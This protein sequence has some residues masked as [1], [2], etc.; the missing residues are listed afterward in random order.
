[1][2]IQTIKQ[3]QETVGELTAKVEELSTKPKTV[4]TSEPVKS[5]DKVV[6]TR[7]ASYYLAKQVSGKEDIKGFDDVKGIIATRAINPADLPNWL[8][9]QFTND[10]VERMT[11][12]ANVEK[13][14][15]HYTIP[16]NAESLSV[17]QKK[18]KIRAYLIAPSTDAINSAI[19][20]AKVTFQAKRLVALTT[21]S[22]QAS[23]ETIVALVDILKQDIAEALV[24]AMEN[25]IIN[26]DTSTGDDNI[27]GST[28]GNDINDQTKVFNGL[29]KITELRNATTTSKVDFGGN[30]TYANFLAMRKLMGKEGINQSD[31]VYIVSPSTYH[32]MLQPGAFPEML[33]VEK[34]GPNATI[35]K[36]HIG[37]INMIPVIVTELIPETLDA[38][39]KEAGDTKTV[40]LLVNTT[41]FA[42]ASRGNAGYEKDRNI[43]SAVN[44]FTGYR[45]VDFKELS[46]G[47][48]IVSSVVGH[49]IAV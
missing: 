44:L 22:D 45:D 15:K 23:D 27:N 25:A 26:G 46:G 32:N 24:Y 12:L 4:V 28:I 1:M 33:T 3:L 8:A 36:G 14:F 11:L 38:N 37:Y 48:D 13:L 43:V 34:F 9:E 39:G 2:S 10:L 17:A 40:A 41:Y 6:A 7:A 29:R 18:D 20:S 47:L 30:V 31:L 19:Q 16:A 42:T 49:N 21:S 35:V 5:D